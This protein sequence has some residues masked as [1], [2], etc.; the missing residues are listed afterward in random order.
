MKIYIP[1][2]WGV[3]AD[4]PRNNDEMGRLTAGAGK[5]CKSDIDIWHR[6]FS[7]YLSNDRR[8]KLLKKF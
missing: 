2:R 6:I 4:R 3:G 7:C 8:N 1:I 5:I